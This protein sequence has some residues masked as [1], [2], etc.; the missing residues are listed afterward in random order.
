MRNSVFKLQ[1]KRKLDR[2]G[3]TVNVYAVNGVITNALNQ[4]RL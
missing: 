4:F 1:Y 3:V 2:K